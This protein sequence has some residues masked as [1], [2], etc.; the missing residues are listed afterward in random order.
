MPK[1]FTDQISDILGIMEDEVDRIEND[2]STTFYNI[3]TRIEKLFDDQETPSTTIVEQPLGTVDD[4]FDDKVKKVLKLQGNEAVYLQPI[5]NSINDTA[6]LQQQLQLCQAE[7]T[8]L[9]ELNKDQVNTILE[10]H[11]EINELEKNCL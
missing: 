6:D 3:I 11:S 2:M 5:A 4:L 8:R 1:K 9:T 10:L 7:I